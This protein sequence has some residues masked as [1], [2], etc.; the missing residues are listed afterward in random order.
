VWGIFYVLPKGSTGTSQQSIR[1]VENVHWKIS[2]YVDPVLFFYWHFR[3]K[4][5][6]ALLLPS[7]Y[8]IPNYVRRSL[9]KPKIEDT[10]N[11]KF[12]S[13]KKISKVFHSKHFYDAQIKTKQKHT[14]RI[15]HH[16]CCE[17]PVQQHA[18]L[19]TATIQHGYGSDQL[20]LSHHEMHDE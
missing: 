19:H 7:C 18:Q 8:C 4:D 17:L 14:P 2:C 6:Y 1:A 15:V 3:S 9:F 16:G 10:S 13:E 12:N 11:L 20:Y 5:I